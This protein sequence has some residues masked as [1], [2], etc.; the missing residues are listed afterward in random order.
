MPFLSCFVQFYTK[1]HK[2][3][4]QICIVEDEESL[5]EMLRMNLEMENFRVKLFNHGGRAMESIKELISADLLILDVM[6]PE[7]SGLEICAEVRKFSQVPILILSAKGMTSDRIQ[8]LKLGANDYLAKPFDLEE[9]LLRV[10]NLL[11]KKEEELRKLIIGDK[12]VFLDTF[13]VKDPTGET[14]V[15]SKREIELL[16]FF[17]EKKGQV[18]SRDEILAKIWGAES[19]PTSRTIDNYILSFRKLFENDPKDP[20]YF[21][22]IRSVGYK[23]T[24]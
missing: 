17:S 19:F 8:G 20:Q 7:K 12:E 14:K 3:M 2:N 13:E 4:N 11:P 23:F 18:V 1:K 24:P 9:L 5:G 10:N 21:H 22:S 15:L 16:E 6:L